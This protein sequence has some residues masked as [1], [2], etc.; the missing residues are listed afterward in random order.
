L[1]QHIT[2]YVFVS[3][4]IFKD[5]DHILKSKHYRKDEHYWY[6]TDSGF[7]YFMDINGFD[8]IESNTMESELGRESIGTY[9]FK[10]RNDTRA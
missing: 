6:F 9:V 4:P 1:L 8:F 7:K 10:A 5:S 3:I 2:G